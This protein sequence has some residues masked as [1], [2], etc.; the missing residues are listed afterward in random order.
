M[1]L[2][3]DLPRNSESR[4]IGVALRHLKRHTDWKLLISYAD[5]SAGHVGVVY[6]ASGWLYVGQGDP[7]TYVRLPDRKL[8]HPRSVYDQYGTNR[9]S[10][11]RATGI[12]A[13]RV[14]VPGKH[15][16][17]YLLDP[18]WRWRIAAP[19]LPYP[20]MSGRGPPANAVIPVDGDPE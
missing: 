16:Y 5:P 18:A 20:R 10:H 2:R 4:V 6:Q 13:E 11:L 3:D 17:V 9:V 19:V 12:D 7:T 15:R 14:A 1:W 8:H